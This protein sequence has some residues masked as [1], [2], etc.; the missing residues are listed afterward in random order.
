VISVFP[1]PGTYGASTTY[2]VRKSIQPGAIVALGADGVGV[3][4]VRV[5][6]VCGL[7]LVTFSD[8]STWRTPPK[9][10]FL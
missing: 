9:S 10:Y 6:S 4:R 3:D 5:S 7:V 8:G 1:M 2:D